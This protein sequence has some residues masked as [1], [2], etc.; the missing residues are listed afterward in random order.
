MKQINLNNFIKH[1][2]TL[3]IENINLVN[4]WLQNE[5]KIINIDYDKHKIYIECN[6]TK[7]DFMKKKDAYE[8][9]NN[10]IVTNIGLLINKNQQHLIDFDLLI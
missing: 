7:L 4:Q 3:T 9:I 10:M 1:N 2:Q 6:N 8:N 5:H